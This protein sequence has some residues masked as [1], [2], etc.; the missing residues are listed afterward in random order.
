MK[1]KVQAPAK[2]N[3]SLDILGRRP[4]GY[5]DV[6]MVMQTIDLYDTVTI[7]ADD[8]KEITISCGYPGVPCDEHNLAYKAAS[9]FFEYT[10]IEN[11]GIVIDI[12]KKIPTQAGMAGGSTDAAAVI[13]GLNKMF[14]TYLPVKTMTEVSARLGADVPFCVQGGTVRASGTGTDLH[15]LAPLPDCYIVVCKPPVSV[16]TAEAYALCDKMNFT[17]PPFTQEL[18]KALYLRDMFM[19]TSSLYND[20]EVALNLD[21]VMDIKKIMYKAKSR[22]AVMTGSGSA[23]FGIFSSAKRA[24]KCVDMLKEKYAC[25]HLCRPI[26]H[27]CAIVDYSV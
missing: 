6:L 27:G 16:S 8:S 20:F 12:E 26:K 15:K 17:H 3:L 2:I 18:V 24:E 25:V 19:I 10:H 11:P 5:H 9:L 13:M 22:G 14:G 21:E 4:D 1:I 7:T 23:V